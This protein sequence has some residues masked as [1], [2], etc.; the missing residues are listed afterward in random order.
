MTGYLWFITFLYCIVAYNISFWLVYKDGPFRIFEGFRRIV[1][2]ISPSFAKVFECM[3][4]TPMWVGM[5]LSGLNV[6]FL[7]NNPMTPFGIVGND[8]LPW[9]SVI[10]LDGIFTSGIVYLIDVVENR[11]NKDEDSDGDMEY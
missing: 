3:N 1:A 4:C 9:Y 5:F 2:K 11:L 8:F 10:I 7:P 6:L